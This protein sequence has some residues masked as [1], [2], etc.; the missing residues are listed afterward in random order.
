MGKRIWVERNKD[1]SWDAFSEDGAHVKFGHGKGLFSPGDLMKVALAGCGALSSEFAVEHT[2]GEGHGAHI[3]VDGTYDNDSD[4]YLAFE[5]QI[6]VD[7]N[8]ADLSAEDANKLEERVRRHIDKSCTV[9]HTMEQITPVR[10]D[11]T[12]RR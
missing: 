5:E 8:D 2:V 9:K 10:L 1:G 11:V 6:T 3:V 12:I 4:S 7:A